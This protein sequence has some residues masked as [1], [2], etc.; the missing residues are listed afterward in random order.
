VASIRATLYPADVPFLYFVAYP[1]GHHEFRVKLA[2]H[3]AAARTARHAWDALRAGAK[4]DQRPSHP[5]TPAMKKP[6]NTARR[7]KT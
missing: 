4:G 1:D 2:E 6:A 3:E 5:V 7:G